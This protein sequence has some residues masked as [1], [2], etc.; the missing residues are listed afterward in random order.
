MRVCVCVVF[1]AAYG[2]IPLIM[3]VNVRQ[4]CRLLMFVCLPLFN[5]R[6][7]LLNS[8]G[9]NIYKS[10]SEHNVDDYLQKGVRGCV[11]RHHTMNGSFKFAC[12]LRVQLR[13]LS[14][15]Y[16]GQRSEVNAV[17]LLDLNGH[18]P[19]DLC[20]VWGQRASDVQLGVDPIENDRRCRR[21]KKIPRDNCFIFKKK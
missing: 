12:K 21:E 15:C 1:G 2:C 6:F 13:L 10:E 14:R 18:D 19:A 7:L 17:E 8:E 20:R 9:E 16:G 3:L 5:T 4:C 11:H